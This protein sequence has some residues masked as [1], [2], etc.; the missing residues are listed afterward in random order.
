P[1]TSGRAVSSGRVSNAAPPAATL[2]IR[3][4]R[5]RDRAPV[6]LVRG[7]DLGANPQFQNPKS[8]VVVATENRD[9]G[10]KQGREQ[11]SP[12]REGSDEQGGQRQRQERARRHATLDGGHA[13]RALEERI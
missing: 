10:I 2:A 5:Q 7:D 3:G 12:Q 1:A 9:H 11:P 13:G 6:V 4:G 8:A